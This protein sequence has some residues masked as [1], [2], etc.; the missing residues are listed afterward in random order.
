[1][2]FH[3][4]FTFCQLIRITEQVI[5]SFFQ[6]QVLV[7]AL[8]FNTREQPNFTYLQYPS[9][10]HLISHCACFLFS[11]ILLIVFKL[12]MCVCW[13]TFII[14]VTTSTGDL[15]QHLQVMINIL[16]SEDRIKLVRDS[17]NLF[18]HLDGNMHARAHTHTQWDQW[19]TNPSECILLCNQMLIC[20]L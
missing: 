12:Q 3:C 10:V 8:M 19:L 5:C 6:E 16:R 11:L 13:W 17:L 2:Q 4:Q 9:A 7:L 20:S 1:M 14:I 18:I 15:P